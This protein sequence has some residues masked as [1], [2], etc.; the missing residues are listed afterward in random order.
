MDS[1]RVATTI[2]GS[3]NDTVTAVTTTKTTTSI[4]A[5]VSF[6]TATQTMTGSTERNGRYVCVYICTCVHV[7]LPTYV[8]I[9][10]RRYICKCPNICMYY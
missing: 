10:I 4:V 7:K 8:H 3:A 2:N 9:R 6:N 5:T 1:K